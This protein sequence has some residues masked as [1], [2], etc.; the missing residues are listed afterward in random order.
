MNQI[1]LDKFGAYLIN[2]GYKKGSVQAYMHDAKYFFVFLQA[3]TAQSIEI[4][5]LRNL[6]KTD[7]YLYINYLKKTKANLPVTINRKLSALRIFFDFLEEEGILQTNLAERICLPVPSKKEDSPENAFR[8]SSEILEDHFTTLKETFSLC[9]TIIFIFVSKYALTPQEIV[10]IKREDIDITNGLL[11]IT[12]NNERIINFQNDSR[13]KSYLSALKDTGRY[14]LSN[15]AENAMS[16][17]NVQLILD[18]ISM[19]QFGKKVSSTILRKNA[20]QN[21]IKKQNADLMQV[22]AFLGL[23]SISAVEKYL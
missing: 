2:K 13:L 19:A 12:A 10:G 14:L 3:Q 20:V 9:E 6:T 15:K 8:I 22:K 5:H 11:H 1:L 7:V 17:R 4:R 21:Y 23:K 18:K 16:T